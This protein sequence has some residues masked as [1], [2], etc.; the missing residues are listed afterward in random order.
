MKIK[1][2]STLYEKLLTILGSFSVIILW[3]AFIKL[4]L[5]YLVS[6]DFFGVSYTALGSF[7]FQCILAPL[8]EE[9][10]YR[11][12]PIQIAR[13]LKKSS[14]QDFTIP[15]II[16]SSALFGWGH[17]NGPVSLIIQGVMGVLLSYVYIKNNYSYWSSVL[18]HFLWNISISYII[19]L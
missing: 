14:G 13:K 6:Y 5:K 3:T 4:D 10:V 17:G 15:I 12:A 2:A 1:K 19:T 11:Y 8:W 7:V 9:G 16:I 18:V